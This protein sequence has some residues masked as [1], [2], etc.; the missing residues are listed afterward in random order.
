MLDRYRSLEELMKGE[1]EGVDYRL[2]VEDRNH[3]VTLI[4][5]HGG[6]IEPGTSEVALSVAGSELNLFVF[7]G[8]KPRGNG[9]LH[10]A[11]TRFRHPKLD[12]LL[13]KSRVAISIHGKEGHVEGIGVGGLNVKLATLILRSLARAGFDAKMETDPG[14]NAGLPENVVNMVRERGVQLELT[15]RLRS[16]LRREGRLMTAFRDAVRAALGQ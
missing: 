2:I 1:R 4:A 13:R 11:S 5:P 10:V 3:E 6:G 8:I 7:E 14:L 12:S 9:A 16:H 15:R